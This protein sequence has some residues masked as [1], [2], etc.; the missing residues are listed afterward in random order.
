MIFKNLNGTTK[1]VF[2]MGLGSLMVFAGSITHAGLLQG[3]D[4]DQ[5]TTRDLIQYSPRWYIPA[6]YN[7]LATHHEVHNLV[8]AIEVIIEAGGTYEMDEGS[9]V[10]I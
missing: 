2:S 3:Q 9:I 5:R 10:V 1:S 4:A 8:G 7:Q 6:D